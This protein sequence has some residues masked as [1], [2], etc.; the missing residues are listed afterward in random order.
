MLS[1]KR[2][3][4]PLLQV[5]S[6]PQALAQEVLKALEAVIMIKRKKE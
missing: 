5:V 6:L 4:F 1:L 3:S 2:L